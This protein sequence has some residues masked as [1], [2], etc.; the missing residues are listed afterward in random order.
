MGH[1]PSSGLIGLYLDAWLF[2]CVA[3]PVLWLD[4]AQG[5]SLQGVSGGVRLPY[6]SS[7]WGAGVMSLKELPVEHSRAV[8]RHWFAAGLVKK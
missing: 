5:L 4:V 8:T 6:L 2:G 1:S 7:L 3:F